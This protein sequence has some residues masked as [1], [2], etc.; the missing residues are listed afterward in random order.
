MNFRKK[1]NQFIRRNFLSG[2]GSILIFFL[3]CFITVKGIAPIFIPTIPNQTNIKDITVIIPNGGIDAVISSLQNSGFRNIYAISHEDVSKTNNFFTSFQTASNAYNDD[4]SNLVKTDFVLYA[5]LK[6]F[7]VPINIPSLP[8]K[9]MVI[10]YAFNQCHES[11]FALLLPYQLEY[12]LITKEAMER[13]NEFSRSLSMQQVSPSESFRIFADFHS[14]HLMLMP[15]DQKKKMIPKWETLEVI[16]NETDFNLRPLD[17]IPK[18]NE[19]WKIREV[20]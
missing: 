11:N 4:I 17:S 13:F 1:R 18:I 2:P 16:E 8:N 20:L 5:G 19:V 6:P 9:P 10:G 7:K 12:S 15:C 14:L 3:I